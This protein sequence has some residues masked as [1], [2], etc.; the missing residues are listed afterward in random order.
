MKLK[1]SASL[2][3]LILRLGVAQAQ[4]VAPVED[5]NGRAWPEAQ[6]EA[7]QPPTQPPEMQPPAPPAQPPAPPVEAQVQS[8]PQVQQPAG[9]SPG[10]GAGQWVYTSEYGWIWMPYG[11]Q[12]TYEG[13][14]NDAYPYSYVYYPSYGWMWLAAPWVWGWGAYPYF[15]VRGPM[16]FGWYAGLYHAGYGWGGYRGGGPGRAGVNPGTRGG[17]V[18]RTASDYHAAGANRPSSSSVSRG[19]FSG[20]V[21]GGHG[22]HR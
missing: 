6:P 7:V 4:G 12:Y 22:G 16:G 3:F 19:G 21:G 15:G 11:N 8:Q 18:T 5:V 13:T 17:G 20:H 14:P 1:M 9:G 2:Y 10:A